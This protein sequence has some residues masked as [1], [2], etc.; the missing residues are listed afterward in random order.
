MQ[1][2][3]RCFSDQRNARPTPMQTIGT[4]YT[5]LALQ[6]A[7]AVGPQIDATTGSGLA[8]SNALADHLSIDQCH[9]K[10]I[11]CDVVVIP[12]TGSCFLT[13]Y[14]PY[15]FSKQCNSEICCTRLQLTWPFLPL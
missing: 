8:T 5:R 7:Q 14:K 15:A 11:L 13:R 12:C 2:E 10:P 6:K 4:S 1:K 3:V 9:L